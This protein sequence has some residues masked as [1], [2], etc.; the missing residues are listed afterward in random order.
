[1]QRTDKSRSL[2]SYVVRVDAGFAPNPYHGYCT[3]AT[4]KPQIRKHASVGDWVIGTGSNAAGVGRGNHLVY[5]MR[6]TEKLCTAQYWHDSRFECKKPIL[7]HFSPEMRCG[8]N[9]YEPIETGEWRQLPSYHSKLDGC[10]DEEQMKHDTK[11]ARVLVSCD[12]LYFGGQGPKL[13]EKF[14]REGTFDLV[15]KGP[16]H[17]RE[18]RECVISEFEKW[19]KSPKT[20]GFQSNPRDQDEIER[21]SESC[22]SC[23]NRRIPSSE[24]SC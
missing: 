7:H 13:A 15:K 14:C 2:F 8:D 12:F 17:K 1:M 11:V 4:C 5:G 3:L 20:C 21:K 18:R 22:K 9:I 6:I 24:T 23:K 16:G 19:L 10:P